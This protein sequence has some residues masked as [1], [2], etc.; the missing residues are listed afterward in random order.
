LGVTPSYFP[1][2]LP[3]GACIS[4]CEQNPWDT[5]HIL[6]NGDV[7]VCEV[8]DKI[9]MGNLT[10]DTL[11]DVWHGPRYR[12]FRRQYALG[13]P[14]EC[15]ACPWKVAYLPVALSTMVAASKNFQPQLLTGW[16]E[17]TGDP[18][19]SGCESRMALQNFAGSVGIRFRGSLPPGLQGEPNHLKIE[20]NGRM[21]AAIENRSEA[22]VHFDRFLPF[23]TEEPDRLQ[24]R[25]ITRF[26]FIP[27]E[28]MLSP[29]SRPLG[30]GL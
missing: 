6:A 25:F 16:F 18:V 21:L 17:A 22:V 15:N 11:R 12:T 28:R 23:A 10:L 20:C 26:E 1:G 9:P 24:L 2:P 30:F 7:V 5:A 13:A 27:A 3:E 19:W 8:R 14:P 29:D 4:T